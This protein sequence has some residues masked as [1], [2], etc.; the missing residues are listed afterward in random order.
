MDR[1][2]IKTINMEEE[3]RMKIIGIEG[4]SDQEINYEIQRGGKFVVYK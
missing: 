3:I 2:T 4:L 1:Q